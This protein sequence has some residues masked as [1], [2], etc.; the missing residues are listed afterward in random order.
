M[1]LLTQYAPRSVLFFYYLVV[2]TF[3][4]RLIVL[5]HYN[6]GD[7]A[8]PLATP[9]PPLAQHTIY[10]ARSLSWM[11]LFDESFS[12]TGWRNKSIFFRQC[13]RRPLRLLNQINQSIFVVFRSNEVGV[14]AQHP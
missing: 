2:R 1:Q 14:L 13:Q 9:S 5:T 11:H 12:Q 3:A 7:G 10:E 8:G 6:S 4:I